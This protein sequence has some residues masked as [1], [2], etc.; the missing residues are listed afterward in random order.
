MTLEESL[1][2]IAI[3]MLSGVAVGLAA[4]VYGAVRAVYRI[5][6]NVAHFLDWLLTALIG[7]WAFLV[8]FATDWGRFRL[9]PILWMAMGYVLWVSLAAP[10]IYPLTR[11]L[12]FLQARVVGF[13][14]RPLRWLFT[15]GARLFHAMGIR[16]AGWAKK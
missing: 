6:R 16:M 10:P 8:L 3:W 1:A 14:C 2:N 9:W 5:P 7:V 4:T 15:L 12:L 11:R 13:C